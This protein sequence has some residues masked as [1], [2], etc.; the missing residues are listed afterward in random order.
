MGSGTVTFERDGFFSS[1]AEG[2]RLRTREM[3]P[4]KVWFD[5]ALGLNRLGYEI[6]RSWGT[7]TGRDRIAVNA[8]FVRVHKSFQSVIILAERGLVS[9][10]RAVLRSAV[11]C[12]IAI[13]ALA[14]DASF[15][16][17]MI[18]AHHRAERTFAREFAAAPSAEKLAAIADADAYEASMGKELRVIH[19]EQVAKRHC[20]APLYRLLYQVLYRDLSSDGTHATINSLNRLLGVEENGQITAIKAAPDT[21]GLVE[22]LPHACLVF[23]LSAEVCANVNGLADVA[24]TLDRAV[25]EFNALDG[26]GAVAR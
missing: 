15:F 19:W 1:Q 23:I 22:V 16:E 4:F 17:Q 3:Q 5:Y 24:T 2:F 21:N 10:A 9:D 12:A 8:S 26:G 20:P 13:Q 14:K 18:E 25:A 11:E 7:L 6:L